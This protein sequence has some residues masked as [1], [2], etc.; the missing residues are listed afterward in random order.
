MDTNWI[1]ILA[2]VL[3]PVIAVIITLWHQGRKE[4]RDRKERLFTQLMA[5]RK[6]FPP[7]SEFVNALN[8]IDIIFADTS[9]VIKLW[10][11]YYAMLGSANTEN[12]YR[13]Q[14]GQIPW[15]FV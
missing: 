9:S 1:N 15:S 8:L 6:A 10:H 11:E 4:R 12:E 5:H 14:Y 2:I 13:E 3:S 7:S